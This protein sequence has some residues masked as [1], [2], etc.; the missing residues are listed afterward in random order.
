VCAFFVSSP[1]IFSTIPVRSPTI[2]SKCPTVQV[3][4]SSVAAG[5][6]GCG[7]EVAV[8]VAVDAGGGGGGNKGD[9]VS[10]LVS[11]LVVASADGI[12]LLSA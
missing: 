4:W 5:G 9:E 12:P 8:A 6:G 11:L 7:D 1:N 3:K 10:L 2:F